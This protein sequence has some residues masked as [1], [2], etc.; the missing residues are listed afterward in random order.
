MQ[1]EIIEG[2]AVIVYPQEA[3]ELPE[4]IVIF[5]VETT[6]L[7]PKKNSQNEKP[8]ITQLSYIKYNT[9][10]NE[11][12]ETFD[13]YVKIPDQVIVSEEITKITGITK[14]MCNAGLPIQQV[15]L[16]FY[17][18][19]TNAECVI[20][21][22]IDFDK[23]MIRIEFMRNIAIIIA[24]VP[25]YMENPIFSD[26]NIYCTMRNSIDLCNIIRETAKGNKYKKF[27]KLIELYHTL[28][29]G[30]DVENLHN[31]YIDT[32]VCLR[33]YLKLRHNIDVA[34]DMF[35]YWLAYK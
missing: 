5:D 33:C 14:E 3:I 30:K 4:I 25:E 34:D 10:T 22:N 9:K 32:L 28:F 17:F 2:Y 26:K 23:E 16:A 8:Y 29:P 12:L 35:E 24:L 6:G 21:H 15:L 7:L 31:S 13:S 18:A 1:T 19:C 11:I 27:P 20:A